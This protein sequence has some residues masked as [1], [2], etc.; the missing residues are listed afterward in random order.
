MND[1]RGGPGDDGPQ[2]RYANWFEI[3]HNEFEFILDFGQHYAG[4]EPDPARVQR[5]TRIVTTPVYA[6]ALLGLL[7]D[8]VGRYEGRFGV[9]RA[10]A[11]ND[12]RPDVT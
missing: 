6:K 5:H 10:R 11:A 1:E 9:I 12:E 3:G 8:V 7:G 2:G 4:G